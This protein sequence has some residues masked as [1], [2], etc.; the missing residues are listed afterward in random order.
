MEVGELTESGNSDSNKT[1]FS[2]TV[3]LMGV[4]FFSRGGQKI[5]M[6]VGQEPT[7]A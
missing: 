3:S 1:G 5:F 2:Y 6:G 7:F 4:D